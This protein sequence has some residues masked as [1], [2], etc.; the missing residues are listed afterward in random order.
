MPGEGQE[1]E[2]EVVVEVEV[3]AGAEMEE[4]TGS[5]SESPLIFAKY[6]S[7]RLEF[8]PLSESLPDFFLHVNLV[9][10]LPFPLLPP[11]S[12]CTWAFGV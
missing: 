11:L 8:V 5:H 1:K 10:I 6:L 12:I 3:E 9:L 7:N 2:E 4:E